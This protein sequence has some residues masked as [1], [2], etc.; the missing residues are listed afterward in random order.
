MP[1]RIRP[2]DETNARRL[3]CFRAR[4]PGGH[5]LPPVGLG[6]GDCAE[7]RPCHPLRAGRAGRRGG[8][9]AAA[10][11]HARPAVRRSRWPPRPSASMAARWPPTPEGAAALEAHAFRLQASSATPCLEYRALRR[12]RSGLAGT[13]GTLLHLPQADRRLTGDEAKD[14]EATSRASSA[15]MVR[16]GIEARPQTRHRRRCRCACSASMRKA[17]A[18][19]ARPVFPSAISALLLEAFPERIRRHH[20]A[21]QGHAGRLGAELL[22]PRRGAALLR[23]RHA[24][25][26]EPGRQRFHVLG[27][28]APRRRERGCQ[29][30][31]F[32]PQQAR[33]RRLRLQEELGL[34]AASRCTT[35][36]ASHQARSVPDNNPLNPKY[37]LFIAAW[38]RLPLP[39]ANLSGPLIVRGLG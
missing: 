32:R 8:R 34:R 30:V 14:M 2:L 10:G 33:H 19:S 9:R 25:A 23:R 29:T 22:F 1:I 37:R 3:G 36:T 16:K 12:G 13:A 17:C 26:R 5:L 39:V 15:P 24:A 6:A 28:D 31:R 18:T 11:A 21:A 35:A 27:S 7:L 4:P 20:G 38:K